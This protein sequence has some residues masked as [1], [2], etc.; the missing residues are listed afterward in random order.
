MSSPA[1]RRELVQRLVLNSICDDYENLVVSI[2]PAIDRDAR[3]CGIEISE[4]EIVDALRNL[5]D[6][7]W[8]KAYRLGGKNAV[9]FD[10][11][12]TIDEMRDFYGA[13]FH[14]TDAGMKVQLA[15]YGGWPFDDEGALRKDWVQ[16]V[17]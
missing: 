1:S 17:E 4:L 6:L 10:Q 7:G 5:V 15:D 9:E 13:W 12:P 8:A 14:I 16:P 11:M 3:D 2:K